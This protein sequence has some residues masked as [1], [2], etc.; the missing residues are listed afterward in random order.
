MKIGVIGLGVV[1]TANK[2]GFEALGH[3]VLFHD[4]AMGTRIEDV[5]R[6]EV[7]FVCVP[8]PS[9]TNG[10]CDTSVVE[11]VVHELTRL[12]YDGAIAIRSTVP[13]GTTNNLQCIYPGIDIGFVPEF[14]RERRAT[15]DF[16]ENHEV[17]VIGNEDS[18]Y[19]NII[20]NAHGNLPRSTVQ[21]SETEAEI[22]KYYNNV[23]AA[24]RVTFAN[25]MF[26]LCDAF[27]A[28]YSKVKETYM[29]AGKA[30]DLYMDVNANLRGYGGMC[31]PK[32][33]KALISVMDQIGAD[34]SL[35][36][37]IDEDNAKFEPTVFDGMRR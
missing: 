36:K 19:F 27:D 5:L 18:R 30:M 2:S 9:K 25:V 16:L 32:D 20:A 1:G 3:E 10:E 28:D 12:R 23:F 13:P 31:L 15:E 21:V 26:E 17:L 22:V 8:T 7:I 24:L 35:L 33:V 6:C 4:R 14:L 29:K 37:A 34:F 11:E